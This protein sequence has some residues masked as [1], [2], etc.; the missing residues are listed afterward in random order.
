M[1]ENH[2]NVRVSPTAQSQPECTEVRWSMV[3]LP[4]YDDNGLHRFS[5]VMAVGLGK[6]GILQPSF[7]FVTS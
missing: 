3:A 7:D 1:K 5:H 2:G 6:S 4:N